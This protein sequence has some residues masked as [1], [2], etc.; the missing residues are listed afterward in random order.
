MDCNCSVLSRDHALRILLK[1][2]ENIFMRLAE[3]TTHDYYSLS[4]RTSIRQTVLPNG[5]QKYHLVQKVGQNQAAQ[6][7]KTVP[8]TERK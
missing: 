7:R 2:K 6:M 8:E 4:E 1:P 3:K 5:H